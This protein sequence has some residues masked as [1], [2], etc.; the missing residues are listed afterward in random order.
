M[1]ADLILMDVEEHF[2]KSLTAL[3]N[4]FRRIR[5]GRASPTM[6][7]HVVADAYG[8]P[9][10]INQLAGI[11]V[12]EPTQLLIKPWDKSVLKDIE[13]ALISADLGMAPQ[14]DG[15]QIRLNVPPLSSERRQQLA[16]QAKESAE[17]CKVAMRNTRRDGIKRAETEGK[18]ANASE[19]A[20]RALSDQITDLLKEYEGKA[21]AVLKEKTED[22]TTV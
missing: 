14:N 18:E 11:S 17:K 12:P 20:I 16:A 7:E 3:G 15:E 13:R 5:T 10:P 9:T 21:E 1:D 8:A 6:I 4:D 22:I 2:E 19:D